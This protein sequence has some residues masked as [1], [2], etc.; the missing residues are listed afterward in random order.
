MYFEHEDFVH[1]TLVIYRCPKTYCEGFARKLRGT[2]LFCY[3]FAREVQLPTKQED[4]LKRVD[5]TCQGLATPTQNLLQK[6]CT[7]QVYRSLRGSYR[8]A[9]PSQF[10]M[11]LRGI[12]RSLQFSRICHAIL[13]G[14][15]PSQILRLINDVLIFRRK[16]LAS[17]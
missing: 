11:T 16:V 15:S 6:V 10:A 7:P 17:L 2:A 12:L 14:N 13:C 5:L 8:T 3:E 1:V 4:Y 9:N